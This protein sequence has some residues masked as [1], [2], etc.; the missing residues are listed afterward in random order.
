MKRPLHGFTLVELLVVI[1][2]IGM[3][4]GLLLP[5][6]NMARE[7][8][9]R[10]VCQNNLHQLSAAVLG[11]VQATGFFP[12]GGWGCNWVGNPDQ[13]TGPNQP[14]GWIY[15][16]LPYL[17]NGPLHDLGKGLSTINPSVYA[18]S[19]GTRVCGFL[20]VLYCP[21]RRQAQAYPLGTTSWGGPNSPRAPLY[22]L[23][24]TSGSLTLPA[25]SGGQ[26]TAGRTDY[27]MNGGSNPPPWNNP[28]P[29]VRG[30]NTIFP[31]YPGPPNLSAATSQTSPYLWPVLTSNPPNFAPA[32]QNGDFNGIV[33]THSQVT[34]AMITD[35]KGETYLIGEKYLLTENYYPPVVA[36]GMGSGVAPYT[37][38]GTA[39]P[40]GDD[41]NQPY[42]GAV[43]IDWGDLFS[44]MSG[45][46]VSQIR[47]ANDSLGWMPTMD[48]SGYP[49]SVTIN[50]S[51]I[52]V[53]PNSTAPQHPDRIFGSAHSAGWY[54]AFCDGHVQLMNWGLWQPDPITGGTM[55]QA[56]ATRNFH[57]V[58]N[59]TEIP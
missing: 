33:A 16:I 22:N 47:W 6:V 41:N 7:S 14:G 55:H 30:M 18:S 31:N 3:L 45:D 1:S 37:T 32:S 5:A 21:T 39:V 40:D 48:R 42:P 11:H 27:A 20:P 59:R 26:P 49:T 15:Q 17:D 44:A 34:E 43:G 58:I 12:S 50:G 29:H 9:R 24:S 52:T 23:G 54:A 51:S 28:P 8:S 57:E 13:G 56:M 35:G 10:T 19:G 46:D 53:I 2:I 25:Q 4:V 36:L 38:D